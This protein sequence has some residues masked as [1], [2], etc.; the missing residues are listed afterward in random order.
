MNK[1]LVL[2]IA[3]LSISVA[4]FSGCIGNKWCYN[5][6]ID[7]G[8]TPFPFNNEC[9]AV[10]GWYDT[11]QNCGNN[12]EGK[13]QKYLC[14][15][16]YHAL[17]DTA[18]Q[19]YVATH[20][21][22]VSCEFGDGAQIDNM[23]AINPNIKFY[24]YYSASDERTDYS[25]WEEVNTHESWFMHANEAHGGVRITWTSGNLVGYYMNPASGWADYYAN[26]CAARLNANTEYYS[27]HADNAWTDW[28]PMGGWP[29]ST[30]NFPDLAD[31]NQT[32]VL[33]RHTGMV[34]LLT[35]TRNTIGKPFIS[36]DWKS[37][38]AGNA[39][40]MH[41]WENFMHGHI[42]DLYSPGYT[43][44]GWN[45]GLLAIDYMERKLE[46]S[47]T[48]V[49]ISGTG[50]YPDT[51]TQQDKDRLHQLQV[52]TLC[53]FLFTVKSISNSYYTWATNS[54]GGDPSLSYFDEMNYKFGNPVDSYHQ[55]N[56]YLYA[57]TFDDKI[58]YANL[59]PDTSYTVGSYT[60]QPRS[61]LIIDNT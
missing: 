26:R 30:C 41:M 37:T 42:N 6:G 14:F 38:D 8:D 35:K 5:C 22:A 46:S 1:T 19:L 2:T 9:P 3:I 11:P 13:A 23:H 20:F 15:I 57:R 27:I 49:V 32:E 54:Y 10:E 31:W 28:G 53:C 50:G 47:A 51:P 55:I 29:A 59:S 45:N 39:S 40:D 44:G 61:G 34:D 36:N 33:A 7:N 60:L 43:T 17:Y 25:D 4:V 48:R 24:G 16:G 52:F 56:G 58:V 12:T 21:D 18:V